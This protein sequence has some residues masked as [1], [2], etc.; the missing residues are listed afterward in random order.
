[1]EISSAGGDFGSELMGCSFML[2]TLG[3]PCPCGFDGKLAGCSW[4]VHRNKA[5]RPANLVTFRAR[6]PWTIDRNSRQCR[7]A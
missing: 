1:M 4:A 2:W 3:R 5:S 7:T 6:L